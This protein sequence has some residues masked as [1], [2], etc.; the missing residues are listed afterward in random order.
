MEQFCV[1]SRRAARV[2][3]ASNFPVPTIQETNFTYLPMPWKTSSCAWCDE[4]SDCRSPL[5]FCNAKGCCQEGQCVT[6]NDCIEQQ[7]G[8]GYYTLQ[9]FDSFG[10]DNNALHPQDN[11]RLLRDACDVNPECVGYNSYGFLKHRILAP[12]LLDPQP[13]VDGLV[14][15][16]LYVKRS[17]VG[18]N[19]N[20]GIKNIKTFCARPDVI[21][22]SGK[23]TRP[24]AY[25]W[26]RNCIACDKDAECPPSTICDGRCCVNNPCY[27]ATAE[28]GKWVDGQYTREPQCVC[29]DDKPYCCMSNSVNLNSAFCSEKPC[30]AQ[31]LLTG[32]NYIC[33]DP[34]RKYDAVMCKANERCCNDAEGGPVCCAPGSDCDG[35]AQENKCTSGEMKTCKS[36]KKEYRDVECFP[37]QTCCNQADGPPICCDGDVK[38]VPGDTN[39]CPYQAAPSS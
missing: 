27:T 10:S 11:P 32:C 28:D 39:E 34:D 19:P 29:S 22:V 35:K 30:A 31:N 15:W 25:G 37:S 26:C 24:K 17:A 23:T 7:S 4:D 12:P 3:V 14:P 36:Q 9:G 2:A 8:E 13:D 6:D 16:V 38:C 33:E 20:V 5:H 18:T 21:N 1:K